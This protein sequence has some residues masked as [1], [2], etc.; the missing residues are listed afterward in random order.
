MRVGILGAGL[1]G[2]TIGSKLAKIGN[3]VMLGRRH[4]EKLKDWLASTG[5]KGKVG[6]L[7]ETAALCSEGIQK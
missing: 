5:I 4:P 7:A 6:S 2:Q 3:E 1:V